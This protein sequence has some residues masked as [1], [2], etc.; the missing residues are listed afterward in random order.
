MTRT[1]KEKFESIRA[2][3][4]ENKDTAEIYGK[5]KRETREN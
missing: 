4:L 1:R 5:S 3:K 2:Y